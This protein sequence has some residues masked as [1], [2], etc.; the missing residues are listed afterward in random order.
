[1]EQSISK[2]QISPLTQ[3]L[4]Q[5]VSLLIELTDAGNCV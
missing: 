2:R 3:P 1:M 4:M 5:Q